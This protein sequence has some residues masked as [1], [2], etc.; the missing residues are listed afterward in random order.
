[1]KQRESSV[2]KIDRYP[3]GQIRHIYHLCDDSFNTTGPSFYI[4][5]EYAFREN[6][7]PIFYKCHSI[8]GRPVGK[9]VT[10]FESGKISFEVT[11]KSD[12]SEEV[13]Y[14]PPH[15][16]TQNVVRRLS[17]DKTG[18]KHGDQFYLINKK[19]KKGNILKHQYDIINEY[20][21][22]GIK[23]IKEVID[24][25]EIIT[26]DLILK[27]PNVEERKVYIQL[28]GPE[29]LLRELNA[30]LID[31]NGKDFL[32][33]IDIGEMIKSSRTNIGMVKFL[34]PSTG[35]I[36]FH[37]VPPFNSLNEAKCWMFGINGNEFKP[38]EEK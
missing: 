16:H 2:I 5:P 33:H 13:Y 6:G 7:Y 1:M 25:P 26:K 20:Y 29:R 3:N 12:G 28:M 21:H 30:T 19:D 23:C 36:Y 17:R 24:H 11:F 35:S 18:E 9:W 22:H 37:L 15:R 34:C 27:T 38:V 31:T 32:Y 14:S 8:D 4:G 10:F